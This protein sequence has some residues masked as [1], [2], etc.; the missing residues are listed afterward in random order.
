[1]GDKFSSFLCAFMLNNDQASSKD[2]MAMDANHSRSYSMS[3]RASRSVRP[4]CKDMFKR[5]LVG[6]LFENRHT[7]I[8][9]DQVVID[10]LTRC[11]P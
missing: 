5:F 2:N 9:P 10:H 1:M 3:E 7:S 8:G 6:G 4:F 11:G